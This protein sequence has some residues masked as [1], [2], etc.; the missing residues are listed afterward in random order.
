MQKDLIDVKLD[1]ETI[2][3]LSMRAAKNNVSIEE[4]ARCILKQA[5][6]P[7]IRLGDLAQ[8]LFGEVNG[9]NLELPERTP[10]DP[11]NFG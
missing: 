6:V 11:I 4:E 10:H 3:H 9:V 5:V 2:R 1:D 7:Q 8:K